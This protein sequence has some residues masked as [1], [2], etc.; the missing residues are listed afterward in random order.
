M[1]SYCSYIYIIFTVIKVR[2]LRWTGLVIYMRQ[3]N[4]YTIR[5]ENF[6]T[7]IYIR[8]V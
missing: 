6:I 5:V 1:C 3:T 8:Y 2:R 4:T 7:Y